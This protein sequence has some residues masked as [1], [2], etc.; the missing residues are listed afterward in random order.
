MAGQFAIPFKTISILF[1]SAFEN[2][3]FLQNQVP[4]CPK[5]K[6]KTSTLVFLIVMVAMMNASI[7]MSQKLQEKDVPAN[8]KTA[9]HKQY[10]NVTKIKWSKED[11]KYEAEF[12]IS[13]EETSVLIDATGSILETEVEIKID[14]LPN[15]VS[16]YVKLNYKGQSIKEVAKIADDKGLVTFE[17]EIKGKDLIF[18]SSGKFIKE[19]K[20]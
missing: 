13:E 15:E 20:D 16:E 18:D 12:E 3:G 11:G 2:S 6:M 8:V 10:P 17:V 19:I 14:Q 1:L 4:S 9:F 7:A 5:N